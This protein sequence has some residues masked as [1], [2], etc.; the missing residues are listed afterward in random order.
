ME[1]TTSFKL[2][3]GL[4]KKGAWGLPS[5]FRAFSIFSDVMRDAKI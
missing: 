2:S 1:T 3:T 5:G 4:T